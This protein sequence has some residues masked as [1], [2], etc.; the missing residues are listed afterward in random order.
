MTLKF[1]NA[2]SEKFAEY[3]ETSGAEQERA[4]KAEI[5]K[6]IEGRPVFEGMTTD[7]IDD[8][9]C[10]DLK[11]MKHFY[12]SWKEMHRILD[13]LENNENEAAWERSLQDDYHPREEQER[14]AKIQREIK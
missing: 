12:G 1:F 10:E 6:M 14:M 11:E 13:E 4:V 9:N 7:Q 8:Q 2:L 3:F 5:I